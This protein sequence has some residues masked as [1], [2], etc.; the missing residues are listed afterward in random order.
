MEKE[1]IKSY[2]CSLLLSKDETLQKMVDDYIDKHKEVDLL[3][4]MVGQTRTMPLTSE[5]IHNLQLQ[6]YSDQ[7]D[8]KMHFDR[9]V[10]YGAIF[11]IAELINQTTC[12][13]YDQVVRGLYQ[14]FDQAFAYCF[15]EHSFDVKNI[16]WGHDEKTKKVVIFTCDQLGLSSE[17]LFNSFLLEPSMTNSRTAIELFINAS[18][19]FRKKPRFTYYH[20]SPAVY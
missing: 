5:F 11:D 3:R 4:T 8:I 20:V 6:L 17:L 18:E 15:K 10:V 13:S 7:T 2:L 16:T 9:Q 19:S 12:S 1:S 14:V